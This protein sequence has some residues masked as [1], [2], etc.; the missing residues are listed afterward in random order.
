[1]A[2]LPQG[3][4]KGGQRERLFAIATAP[5]AIAAEVTIDLAPLARALKDLGANAIDQAVV[6]ALNKGIDGFKSDA[7]KLLKQYTRIKT[8]NR[9][10]KGV[11][12]LPATRSRLEAYYIIRDTNIGITKKRFGAAFAGS[13]KEAA[14]VRWGKLAPRFA[15]SWTSWDGTRSRMHPFMLKGKGP[16]FVNLRK[17]RGRG[18]GKRPQLGME[19]VR[20]PNPA[21]IVRLHVPQFQQALKARADAELVRQIALSYTQAAQKAKAKHGL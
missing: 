10:K 2:D 6:R 7:H 3:R 13:P 19:V 18:M 14:L 11:R 8:P 4:N 5:G 20:G 12:I 17:M 21:Q 1:V 15:T 16:V 9:L